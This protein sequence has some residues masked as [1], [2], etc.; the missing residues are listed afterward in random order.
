M[1]KWIIFFLVTSGLI[2]IAALVIP[3][4][5][6]KRMSETK[7]SLTDEQ[8]KIIAEKLDVDYTGLSAFGLAVL[9]LYHDICVVA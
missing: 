8:I 9:F 7:T 4:L 1:K 6:G 2:I 5:A 3:N